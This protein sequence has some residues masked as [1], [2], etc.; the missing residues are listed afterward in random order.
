MGRF[1]RVVGVVV[2]NGA[3][4]RVLG[5]F[6][7]FVVAEYAVWIGMLVYAFHHGGAIALTDDDDQ[8]GLDGLFEGL[9]EV[10]S[11]DRARLLTGLLT[12]QYVVVG[13]LDVLFVVLAVGVL[14]QGQAWVGYLNAAYGIG[15]VA[16]GVLTAHLLGWRLSQVIGASVLVLG[17][18]LVL[19]GFFHQAVIV[20]LLIGVVGAGRAVLFVAASSLLQRVVPA[21]VVGRVFGVVEGLSNLGLAVGSVLPA[22]L[23]YL[24]GDRLAVV[25][26]GGL[27]PAAAVLGVGPCAVSIR[28]GRCRSWRWPCC[29]PCPTSP[30]CPGRGWRHW[31]G[32]SSACTCSPERSSLGRGTKGTGFTPSPKGKLRFRL[33][34]TL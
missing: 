6:G 4:A 20:L 19:T 22:L 29:V 3:V 23:I 14:H 21:Q 15:A 13:A 17:A 1:F 9:V 5:A 28:A 2:T 31:R 16:A 25:V 30:T 24:G 10:T 26:I 11:D 7:L 8:P 32:N 12:A 18:G 27:L 33:M 34:V